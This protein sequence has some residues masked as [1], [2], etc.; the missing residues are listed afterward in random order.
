MPNQRLVLRKFRK[1]PSAEYGP[2]LHPT[3]SRDDSLRKG[4][5]H[6]TADRLLDW[7]GVNQA[8]KSTVTSTKAKQ[9]NPSKQNK[10]SA[11]Q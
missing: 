1:R 3:F 8:S 6:C 11:V 2:S 5:Y 7:F 4:K 9:L 10:R